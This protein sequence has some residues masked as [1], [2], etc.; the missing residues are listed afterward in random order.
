MQK[1]Q[2]RINDYSD[3]ELLRQYLYHSQDYTQEALEFIRAEIS[4][5]QIDE[6]SLRQELEKGEETQDNKAIKYREEDFDKLESAFTHTDILLAHA[7]LRDQKIPFFVDNPSSSETIPLESEAART[8][9]L[10]VHK[11]YIDKATEILDEHF[12]Q[13]ENMYRLRYTD[14][15]ERLKA[16]NFHDIHLS[17]SSANEELEVSLTPGECQTIVSLGKRYIDEA[18]EIEQKQERILFHY[19]TVELLLEK[20]QQKDD[21]KLCRTELLAILE[22]CQVYC[23]DPQFPESM[24]ETVSSL[25]AFFLQ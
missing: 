13:S 6:N 12:T 20:L 8:F 23:D 3:K 17:E 4:R 24:K 2:E 5:R 9:S 14:V 25:L 16:F 15:L 18:D 21:F 7:I 22:I 19:D 10:Q 11:E 1:L